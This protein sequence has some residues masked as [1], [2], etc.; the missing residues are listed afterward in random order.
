MYLV[1]K[2]KFENCWKLFSESFCTFPVRLLIETRH[3]RTPFYY[4]VVGLHNFRS[5]IELQLQIRYIFKAITS[6][7]IRDLTKLKQE[8]QK[9]KEFAYYERR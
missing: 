9:K 8:T 2:F 3:F 4:T 6:Y 1:N 7:V 5:N